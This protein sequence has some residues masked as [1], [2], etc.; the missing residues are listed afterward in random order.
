MD[1]DLLAAELIAD[2][3]M[4][5]DLCDVVRGQKAPPPVTL[6]ATDLKVGYDVQL[7]F[8][9]Y[10]YLNVLTLS[11]SPAELLERLR[12]RTEATLAR[13]LEQL[14]TA[15][16]RWTR[17]TADET[18]LHALRE[19]K[20]MTLAELR[21]ATETQLGV[22]AVNA[23]LAAL[24]E[25]LPATLDKRERSLLVAQRLWTL[26]GLSGP[27]VVLYYSPPYYPHAQTAPGA[28]HEAMAAVATDHPELQLQTVE[29]Y[30]YISDMSYLR[31]D[32]GMD[33]AA[34]KANMPLWSDEFPPAGGV[35]S[36]PLDEIA[37]LGLPAINLGPY[38]WGAHQRGERL[39][40]SYSFG[41]LPQL[42]VEVI[43]RLGARNDSPTS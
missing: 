18:P 35:Y 32:P 11:S 28:L 37:R 1:A 31:L 12:E 36:L 38:G 30:P 2:L 20:V 39:L 10:F 7:P 33:L 13:V 22:D 17:L 15:E 14:R 42:I 16:E 26:S 9:A 40:Q 21:E 27:A 25:A 23:D 3:S 24:N 5:P 34:L 19:G 29:F 43:E 8:A 6:R 41:V 4:N